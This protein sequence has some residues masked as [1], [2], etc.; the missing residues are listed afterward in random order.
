MVEALQA[1]VA[2]QLQKQQ[3]ATMNANTPESSQRQPSH[4][5]QMDVW[6]LMK[7][8]TIDIFEKFALST[9]LECSKNLKASLIAETFDFILSELTRRARQP[10]APSNF[11]YRLPNTANRRLREQ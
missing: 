11:F 10:L 8:I 7:M 1:R 3:H 2:E 4:C 6:P 9:D 5:M